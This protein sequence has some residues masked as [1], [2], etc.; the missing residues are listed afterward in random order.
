M[1]ENLEKLIA[2]IETKVRADDPHALDEANALVGRHPADARVWSLRSYIRSRSN[3][4]D[5]AIHDISEAISISPLE[6]VFFF[7]RGRFQLRLGNYKD[8]ISDLSRGLEL[9][10]VHENDYYR[11]TLLFFR[12]AA[13]VRVGDGV[14]AAADLSK[15]EDEEFSLWL[16]GLVSKKQLLAECEK[17]IR[18]DGSGKRPRP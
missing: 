10:D 2:S 14:S 18:H 13:Y 3:D 15:I 17:L 8:S 4:F 16:D 11:D 9:C 7:N 6:P 1:T 5:G 12:A